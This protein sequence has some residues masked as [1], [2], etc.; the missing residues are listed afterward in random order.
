MIQSARKQY[1]LGFKFE[2]FRNLNRCI[3][4]KDTLK[5]WV[6]SVCNVSWI[7]YNMA[8]NTTHEHVERSHFSLKEYEIITI[9]QHAGKIFFSCTKMYFSKPSK[10]ALWSWNTDMPKLNW[11]TNSGQIIHLFTFLMIYNYKVVKAFPQSICRE[12]ISPVGYFLL[13]IRGGEGM[14]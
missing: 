4:N 1:Y 14:G 13:M 12:F 2:R 5:R 9:E 3:F 6:W 7:I 8:T 10:H 11:S